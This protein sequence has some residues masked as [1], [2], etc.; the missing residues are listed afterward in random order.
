MHDW[1]RP[2][3]ELSESPQWL[4]DLWSEGYYD[5]KEQMEATKTA[6]T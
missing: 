5:R 4:P 6:Y 1:N 2:T 3:Q